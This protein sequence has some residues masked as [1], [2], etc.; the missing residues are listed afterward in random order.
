MHVHVCALWGEGH[1]DGESQAG[2]TP[3]LSIEFPKV[4]TWAETQ[5]RTLKWPSQQ[6]PLLLVMESE[7]WSLRLLVLSISSRVSACPCVFGGSVVRCLYIYAV[8]IFLTDAHGCEGPSCSLGTLGF[9]SPRL[10]AAGPCAPS[11]GCGW[12]S[13]SA[14]SSCFQSVPNSESGVSPLRVCGVLSGTLQKW[15]SAFLSGLRRGPRD[16][17]LSFSR[18]WG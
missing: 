7:Q 15:C 17:T 1:R 3:P 18:R 9:R 12:H 10:V 6:V 4:M 8:C 13:M 2:H 11:R 16:V 5:S 14:L